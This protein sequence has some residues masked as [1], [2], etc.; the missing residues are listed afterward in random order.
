MGKKW[1]AQQRA[2][3]KAAMAAKREAKAVKIL[4][5][6]NK[7]MVADLPVVEISNG[8]AEAEEFA[9]FMAEAWRVYKGR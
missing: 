7:A 2:N 8:H 5:K 1:T 6:R 9:K 3:F 4:A